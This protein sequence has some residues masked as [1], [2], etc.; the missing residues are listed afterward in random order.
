MEG[1]ALLALENDRYWMADDGLSLAAG[2]IV[3]ALEYA[4]GKSAIVMGKPS[5]TF[6][7]LALDD[8]HLRPEQVAMIGD[9]IIT[10]IG[11]AYHAGMKGILVRTGKF[12][13]DSV[14]AAEI[15]PACIIDSISRIQDVI[16]RR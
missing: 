3:K 4:T 16:H 1:A 8:M 10:D 6:F 14:D 9:D 12:R 7:N 2:P 11:G 15:K 5:Q 13:S